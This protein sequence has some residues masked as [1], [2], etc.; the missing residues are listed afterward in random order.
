MEDKLMNCWAMEQE[1]L[2]KELKNENP[3]NIGLTK[4]EARKRLENPKGQKDILWNIFLSQINSF[5]ILLLMGIGGVSFLISLMNGF[6]D[7]EESLSLFGGCVIYI[8][9]S[10]FLEYIMKGVH[11]KNNSLSMP[12]SKVIRQGKILNLGAEEIVLGDI[13]LLER[14]GY[15][16]KTIRILEAEALKIEERGLFGELEM[17]EK[18]ASLLPENTKRQERKNMIYDGSFVLEGVG[19]GIVVEGLA[20]KTNEN[21]SFHQKNNT[22]IEWRLNETTKKFYGYTYIIS[23]VILLLGYL[24][25]QSSY[26]IFLTII[27]LCVS[28]PKG[29]FYVLDCV[30]GFGLQKMQEQGNTLKSLKALEDLANIDVV[31]LE[32]DFF[33]KQEVEALEIYDHTNEQTQEKKSLLYTLFALCNEAREQNQSEQKEG[34]WIGEKIEIA[35][36]KLAKQ[37]G[38]ER[39]DLLKE[40]KEIGRISDDKQKDK[41]TTIHEL[42]GGKWIS[43]T[44]A[45]ADFILKNC[46]YCLEGYE[47]LSFEGHRRSNANIWKGKLCAKGEKVVAIAYRHW[48]NRPD[49]HHLAELEKDLVFAG[50]VGIHHDMEKGMEDFIKDLRKM[51]IKP[52]LMTKESIGSIQNLATKISILEDNGII[53]DAEQKETYITE[54]EL[55]KLSDMELKEEIGKYQLFTDMNQE[56]QIRV[57]KTLQNMEKRVAVVNVENLFDVADVF[58]VVGGQATERMKQTGNILCLKEERSSFLDMIKGCRCILRNLDKLMIFLLSSHVAKI[59]VVVI[60]LLMGF[61]L[62]LSPIQILSLNLF[63]HFMP[64]L[65][66]SKNIFGEGREKREWL[67]G[68]MEGIFIGILSLGVCHISN[69]FW[70]E[71]LKNTLIFSILCGSQTLQLQ[72]ML[73]K[74]SS[75]FRRFRWDRKSLETIGM[76]GLFQILFFGL[77]MYCD[78]FHLFEIKAMSMVQWGVVFAVSL[79]G[80]LVLS[81]NEKMR[82]M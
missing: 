29:F 19:Y 50:M 67:D 3:F 28:V 47:T 54:T 22:E 46:K 65:L 45:G 63:L 69:N 68:I 13:I 33:R 27:S 16:C 80:F 75:D 23:F 73:F 66:L 64:I 31:C 10:M 8:C 11:Q 60:G 81:W 14:G 71:E 30:V 18:D 53:E 1:A 7:F 51:H 41:L 72:Q 34:E 59:V 35:L 20:K 61:G 56:N 77:A 70:G 42:D 74:K 15:I 55:T 49:I 26:I 2:R 6:G 58:C 12:K 40:M 44:R 78:T 43:I 37:N 32:A 76:I 17:I 52:I 48:E 79:G 38:I 39:A 5:S 24:Q 62:C 36:A 25:G 82:N 9:L 21:N 4:R 57:I